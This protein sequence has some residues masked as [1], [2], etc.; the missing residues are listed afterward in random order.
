ME[1][2]TIAPADV[3]ILDDFIE[4]KAPAMEAGTIA[5]ADITPASKPGH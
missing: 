1:A 2:G 5:P 4:P 3:L